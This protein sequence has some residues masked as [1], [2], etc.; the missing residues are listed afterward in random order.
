MGLIALTCV[1]VG[2]RIYLFQETATLFVTKQL[3]LKSLNFIQCLKS[4]FCCLILSIILKKCSLIITCQWAVRFLTIFLGN[5]PR[6]LLHKMYIM[7]RHLWNSTSFFLNVRN[8]HLESCRTK[9]K[10]GKTNHDRIKLTNLLSKCVTKIHKKPFS[11]RFGIMPDCNSYFSN[12]CSLFPIQKL[13]QIWH[14]LN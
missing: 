14:F 1:K 12:F 9:G 5:H 4:N 6:C 7:I 2:G 13:L 8:Q 11:I 3:Y 10:C